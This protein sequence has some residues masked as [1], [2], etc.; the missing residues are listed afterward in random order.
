MLVHGLVFRVLS[1]I[2]RLGKGSASMSDEMRLIGVEVPRHHSASPVSRFPTLPLRPH[3]QQLPKGCSVYGG[4][5]YRTLAILG[6]KLWLPDCQRHTFNKITRKSEV[7]LNTEM[8]Y[9]DYIVMEGSS[10]GGGRR[11]SHRRRPLI[12]PIL[13][14]QPLRRSRSVDPEIPP[15]SEAG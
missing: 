9:L 13:D 2:G 15:R 4:Y 14:L 10:V 7:L 12:S 11:L 8:A 1:N 3:G 6:H 5:D